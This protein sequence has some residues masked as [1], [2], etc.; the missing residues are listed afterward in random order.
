[1]SSKI[2][3]LKKEVKRLISERDSLFPP[4]MLDVQGAY[5]RASHLS[6]WYA[7][8]D[9]KII[10]GPY[11]SLSDIDYIERDGYTVINFYDKFKIKIVFSIEI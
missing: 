8:L 2:Q 5:G 1:M 7:G 11:M 4:K 3:E 9:F 10:H 6:D